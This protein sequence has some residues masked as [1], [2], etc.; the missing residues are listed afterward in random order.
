MGRA[1]VWWAQ[2]WQGYWDGHP[3]R[4]LAMLRE[5]LNAQGKAGEEFGA[6]ARERRKRS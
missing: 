2:E 1:K 3:A 5:R 6:P 4:E